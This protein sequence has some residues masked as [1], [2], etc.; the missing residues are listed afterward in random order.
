[1]PKGRVQYGSR[2]K[3]LRS[4]WLLSQQHIADELKVDR[5]LISR[6]ESEDAEPGL[7]HIRSLAIM[8]DVSTDYLIG[9]TT[10]RKP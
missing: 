6:W 1:M 4:E 2:I 3:I 8:F 9:L 10:K 5:S 7:Q